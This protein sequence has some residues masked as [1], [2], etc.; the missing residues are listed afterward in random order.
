MKSNVLYA[1]LLCLWIVSTAFSQGGNAELG[2]VVTDPSKALI[3]GVTI[4]A[5][6]VNT[7]I[8]TTQLTN[9]SGIY[10]FPV[11]QPGTYEI[12]AELSG[13][14]KSIQKSELPYAGQV[15]ANFTLEIGQSNQTVDVSVSSDSILRETSASVGDVLS[16]D[17]IQNLPLV[18]NNV[19]DLLETLPGLRTSPAG[20]SFDTV[21]GLNIDTINVTRDGLTIND[22][23]YA[24]GSTDGRHGDRWKRPLPVVRHDAASRSRRGNPLDP[25]SSGCGTRT[26][27]FANPDSNAFRNE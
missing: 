9:E 25:V 26:R 12:S 8:A 15:R 18:G 10:T 14:K 1:A 24:A 21:N 22:G 7:G 19:L 27:Q 11:L 2:G 20:D 5:K 4:T 3:P 16:S 6:N 17:R 13:F 23:R